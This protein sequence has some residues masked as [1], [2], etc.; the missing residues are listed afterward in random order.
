MRAMEH[1]MAFRNA[2]EWARKD[3][4]DREVGRSKHIQKTADRMQRNGVGNRRNPTWDA[5]EA[6]WRAARVNR[7]ESR[8]VMQAARGD[9]GRDTQRSHGGNKGRRWRKSILGDEGAAAI[10]T[11]ESAQPKPA[12]LALT[13][14]EAHAEDGQQEEHRQLDPQED[15]QLE[16]DAHQERRSARHR[17]RGAA[18]GTQAR[19]AKADGRGTVKRGDVQWTTVPTLKKELSS[20]RTAVHREN[21]ERRRAV[22]DQTNDPEWQAQ[23]KEEQRRWELRIQALDK[24]VSRHAVRTRARSISQGR[25]IRTEKVTMRARTS[26]PGVGRAPRPRDAIRPKRVRDSRERRPP[27][28]QEASSSTRVL[29]RPAAGKVR[30]GP[31]ACADTLDLDPRW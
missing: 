12:T 2:K 26:E 21:E 22:E 8:D 16:E 9:T 18:A 27:P 13:L 1:G 7:L 31:G 4:R 6:V 11:I 14:P 28:T 25:T 10:R 29:L 17:G 15:V 23:I 19:N 24:R 5:E 30:Q 3:A 20:A